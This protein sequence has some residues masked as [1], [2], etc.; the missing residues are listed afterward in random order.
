MTSDVPLKDRDY[1]KLYLRADV[2]KNNYKTEEYDLMQYFG[3]LGGLLEIVIVIGWYLSFALVSR[4]FKAAL[5]ER[6]YRYQQYKPDSTQY[7]ETRIAGQVTPEE[8]SSSDDDD[9]ENSNKVE[10]NKASQSK[11]LTVV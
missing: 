6:T 10:E 9:D 7:Y 4:L 3:D 11:P 8:S 2:I 5:V 1:F